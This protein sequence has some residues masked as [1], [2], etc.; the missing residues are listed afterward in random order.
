LRFSRGA[1]GA[2]TAPP[3][4]CGS[5]E[6]IIIRRRTQGPGPGLVAHVVWKYRLR[7]ASSSI[8]GCVECGCVCAR[9]CVRVRVCLLVRA[10]V[11]VCVCVCE[12]ERREKKSLPVQRR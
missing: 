11:C 12:R 8:W 4:S 6:G 1:M 5:G 2:A 10:C 9:V 3:F 7:L